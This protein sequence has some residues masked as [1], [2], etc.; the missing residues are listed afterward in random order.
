MK[1]SKS[2]ILILLSAGLVTTWVY[3]L[4]DKMQYSNRKPETVQIDSAALAQR[5]RDSLQRIYAGTIHELGDSLNYTRSNAD[6][7]QNQLSDKVS[8]IN[9]LRSEINGILGK[10]GVTREELATARQKIAELQQNVDDLR[11]QNGTIEEEKK[12]LMGQMEQLTNDFN[13]LQQNMR[14]VTEENRKLT[15]KVN[16]ASTFVASELHCSPVS[17]R[18]GKEEET[19]QAKKASKLVISF[20]VQN[21]IADYS[22]AEVYVVVTQPDGQV[23][24]N[25]VWESGSMFTKAGGQREYTRQIRFEYTKGEPK[26]LLFSINAEEYQKGNYTMEIYHNGVVIGKAVKSLQ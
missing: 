9:R 13:G 6:S 5:T 19:N 25:D 12:R 20:T 26:K 3:H 14:N 15:E 22:N 18:N 23:L 24:R 7:L 1:D 17:V 4:Y 10:K 8:T 2:L 11:N 21:N 16:Q